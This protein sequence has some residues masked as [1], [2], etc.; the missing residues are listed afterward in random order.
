MYSFP[1]S[2]K[3]C[4][5]KKLATPNFSRIGQMGT[6]FVLRHFFLIIRFNIREPPSP[7]LGPMRLFLGLVQLSWKHELKPIIR[8]KNVEHVVF[9]TAY[10]ME[11]KSA[12]VLKKL[13]VKYKYQRKII[14]KFGERFALKQLKVI[15][16]ILKW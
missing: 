13:L 2:Q 10:S 5:H 8:E 15:R 1:F 6:N 7:L 4:K 3:L 16:I 9:Y 11:I 14:I 12:N